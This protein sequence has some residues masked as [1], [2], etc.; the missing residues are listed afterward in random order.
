MSVD[1]KLGILLESKAVQKLSL[2]IK[3]L[4]KKWFPKLVFLYEKS[5]MKKII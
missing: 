1:Q 4:L 5:S 2:E 3:F